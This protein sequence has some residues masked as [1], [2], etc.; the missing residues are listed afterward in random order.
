ILRVGGSFPVVTR[1][2]CGRGLL[3]NPCLAEEYFADMPPG[4][5]GK[6]PGEPGKPPEDPPAPEAG[7]AE[8]ERKRRKI[9]RF[10]ELLVAGYEA[11]Y[12]E[13]PGI[14]TAKLKE[15]WFYLGDSFPDTAREQKALKKARTPE[16]LI[17]AAEK[18]MEGS[19]VR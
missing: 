1:V 6:T 8:N 2:M 4:T 10:H 7:E 5:G 16:E 12:P 9:R 15:L 17:R 3:R 14:I 13:N 18:V 11:A 19:A